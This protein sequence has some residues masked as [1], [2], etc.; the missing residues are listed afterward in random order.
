MRS[1]TRGAESV[2]LFH[3]I[4]DTL[5]AKPCLAIHVQPHLTPEAQR[6]LHRLQRAAAA[7]WPGSLHLAPPPAFHV[8]IYP[9]VP[10]SEGFDKAA[11]WDRIAEPTRALIEETCAGAPPL[12]LRFDR[13]K[14]MPV[15]IIA[16]AQEETG[17]V[18]RLR[19]AILS[20]LPPPP[21]LEH[22]RYYLVHT[23][24]ARF[25]DPAP[26]GREAVERIERQ[27]VA[28]DVPVDRIKIFR[29]TRF[30]CLVGEELASVSLG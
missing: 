17:L 4:A 5:F 26:V 8:T 23:T 29:E 13:L 15:G 18:E 12:T 7:S 9:L 22:R 20:T 10:T 3:P 1:G 27:P 16:A 28:L 11:Y 30:P 6:A 19:R 25:A 24:L 21:G 14:V 2:D